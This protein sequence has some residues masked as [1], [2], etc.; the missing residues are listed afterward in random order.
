M[1]QNFIISFILIIPFIKTQNSTANTERD[2]CMAIQYPKNFKDCVT[3][4]NLTNGLCCYVKLD[5]IFIY[6]LYI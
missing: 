1:L 2:P 4:S 3:P 6:N 5:F